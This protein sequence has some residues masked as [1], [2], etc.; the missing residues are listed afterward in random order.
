[1]HYDGR[2]ANSGALFRCAAAAVTAAVTLSS[3]SL[4]PYR[5]ARYCPPML[6][7]MYMP[8]LRV[9]TEYIHAFT[10]HECT[11]G[12]APRDRVDID[13]KLARERIYIILELGR[14][15]LEGSSRAELQN[16]PCLV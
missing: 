6:A 12:Q 5:E 9:R 16:E 11:A 3:R 1:M 13:N 7:W 2:L 10:L 15:A 14:H 4:R 8:V